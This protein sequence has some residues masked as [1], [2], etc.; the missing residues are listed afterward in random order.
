MVF[1][2]VAVFG[3]YG[4]QE[5]ILHGDVEENI[6]VRL[7][8]GMLL[9]GFDELGEGEVD[10]FDCVASHALE[11]PGYDQLAVFVADAHC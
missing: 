4:H 8:V 5:Q 1:D 11:L 10:V 6:F 7:H 2:D 9:V 3:G